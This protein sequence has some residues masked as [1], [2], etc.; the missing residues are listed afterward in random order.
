MKGIVLIK[1]NEFIVER[2]GEFFWD[3]LLTAANLPS[4]GAFTSTIIYDNQELMILFR[5]IKKK[6]N[7]SIKRIQQ[8]FGHFFF[9]AIYPHIPASANTDKIKD[10]FEFLHKVQNLIHSEVKKFEPEALLPEFIFIDETP[11]TLIFHYKSNRQ[12]CYFCEGLVHGLAEHTGQSVNVCQ[13]E[14]EHE[15]QQRCLI[16]VEKL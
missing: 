16:K 13:I 2:W 1:F 11:T 4:E 14:C 15:G 12:L 3:D 6:K 7:I 9:S 10:V 8:A 5:L